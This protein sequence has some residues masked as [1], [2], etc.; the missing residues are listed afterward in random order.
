[1]SRLPFTGYQRIP[2]ARN[3][4]GKSSDE[5]LEGN[6]V[7]TSLGCKGERICVCRRPPYECF[8]ERL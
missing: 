8:V 1:M 3:E 2:R 4:A 5:A 6:V 7:G